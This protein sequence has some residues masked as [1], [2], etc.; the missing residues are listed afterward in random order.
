LL[1]FFATIIPFP[2]SSRN[3]CGKTTLMELVAQRALPGI[4]RNMSMLLVRQE[5]MGNELTPVQCVLKS[6]PRTEGLKLYIAMAESKKDFDATK[7]VAAY[8]RLAQ[9]EAEEGAPEPRARK[10]LF[11]LGFSEEMQD[12]PTKELSGGWRMR[13]SLSNALFANPDLLLLDE[14]TS[15]FLPLSFRCTIFFPPIVS[16][17]P[18]DDLL[19]F[20]DSTRLPLRSFGFGG[21]ALARKISF[22]QV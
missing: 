1:P 21:S 4:P 2:I 12:K 10:I 6:D 11:G 9:I 15:K 14:P 13:V 16:S 18:S 22:Y 5:I 3:G 17:S 7:L 19:A 20:P 8:E